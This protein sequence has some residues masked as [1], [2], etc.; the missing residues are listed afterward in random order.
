[1][2][3]FLDSGEVNAQNFLRPINSFIM[4]QHVEFVIMEAVLQRPDGKLAEIS[5]EIQEQRGS[6][7]SISSVLL[8]LNRNRFSRKRFGKDLLVARQLQFPD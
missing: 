5:H 7:C 3:K 4:H 6:E 2:L 1:M 8:Y